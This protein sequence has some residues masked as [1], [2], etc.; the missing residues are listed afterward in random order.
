[1]NELILKKIQ[2][3]LDDDYGLYSSYIEGED[4]EYG[5]P[6]ELVGKLKVYEGTQDWSITSKIGSS[7]YLSGCS[8]IRIIGMSIKSVHSEWPL[9]QCKLL[10]VT[11]DLDNVIWPWVKGWFP[12]T[13]GNF[14]IGKSAQ[15]LQSIL[16]GKFKKRGE[17][18]HDYVSIARRINPKLGYHS[19]KNPKIQ[20][21]YVDVDEDFS[22]RVIEF[23][24]FYLSDDLNNVGK[25]S[26]IIQL[27][28]DKETGTLSCWHT[29]RRL[30][31]EK[32]PQLISLPKE[33]L[34]PDVGN[35]ENTIWDEYYAPEIKRYLEDPIASYR[36]QLGNLISEE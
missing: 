28:I 17:R 27:R 31:D 18:L 2:T 24:F 34:V 36:E 3:R 6:F 22:F 30:S 26:I 19:V 10:D 5:K 21:T 11:G 12:P 33:R 1:M 4:T 25:T 32:E 13:D 20:Y 7:W 23:P 16:S 29:L 15:T 14:M 8:G 35:L 9:F